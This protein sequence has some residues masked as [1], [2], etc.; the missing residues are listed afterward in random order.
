[1]PIA[2]SIA[3]KMVAA[4]EVPYVNL[5]AQ[6][7]EERAALMPV[8]EGVF[9]RGDFIGGQAIGEFE[10]AFAAFVGVKHAI[11]MN[12]GTDA[13]IVG[14]AALGIGP[15]DEVITPPNSFVA[16]TAAICRL[17]AKPVFV[18]VLPDQNIDPDGIERPMTSR[19][20]AIMPVHLTGALR[21]WTDIM[22]PSNA[23]LQVIEDAAQAIGS[24]FDGRS[25]GR[26]VPWAASR[27]TRLR[28]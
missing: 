19:T 14:M 25:R 11:G 3:D 6:F 1:M 10:R 23:G 27:P 12:S 24:K 20:R 21:R 7:A 9:A 17:G 5:P 13:L 26:S 8:I 2:D 18:D 22:P 28:T 15:G 4:R 16:S